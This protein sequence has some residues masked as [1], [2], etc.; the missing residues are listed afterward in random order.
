MSQPD[1]IIRGI[2]DED[3]ARTMLRLALS[4]HRVH[5]NQKVRDVVIYV[6]TPYNR[7]PPNRTYTCHWTRNRKTIVAERHTDEG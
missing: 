4:F 7:L 2:K 6:I 1:I 3:D 5:P